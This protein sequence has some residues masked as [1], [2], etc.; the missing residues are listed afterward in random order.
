[1]PATIIDST[2]FGDIFSTAAMRHIWSDENR[3]Q[4]YLDVEAA[5][6][7]VQARLGIIPQA[8]AD[9]IVRNCTIDKID[10]AKL[11]GP[12]RAHRLPG[13]RRRLAADRAVPRPPRRVLPLGRDDAGHH[14]YGHGAA[15]PR[16]ARSRRSGSEGGLGVAR[17]ARA[18]ASRHA[19]DRP[20]QPAAGGAGHVRLQDGRAA[21]R[22]RAPSRAPRPAAPA[23][24]D[25]RV[26]RRGR[27]AGVA[28]DGRARDA[29][30]P[31]EGA[32]PRAAGHRLAHD[33]RLHRR[34]RLL[35]R[36]GRRDARQAV[37]GREADDADRGRRG[38]RAVR[39]R[40]R[41]EQHHAA[42]AQ[43]DLEVLHPRGG[44]GG[45]AARRRADGRDGRRPRA[46]DRPVGDRVDRAAG[47]VLPDLGRAA[48]GAI[49]CRRPRG[50]RGA[51][52]REPRPHERAGRVRGGDDGARAAT[53]DASTRTISCTTSAA[54]RS[55]RIGHCSTCSPRTPR[56]RST[57]TA[58]SSPRC[59]IRR[60]TSG[61]RV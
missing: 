1:M 46:L 60:T 58:R 5:L 38:V 50:R 8:A 10:M 19:D 36:P 25:R 4:K 31:D 39:A 41:V 11:Q 44:R 51:D 12:D 14:R 32:R 59:A 24:A 27:H 52:A 57:S 15:D 26:R 28:R 9:E 35:P 37:D 16:G 53:S 23:R 30:R 48:A 22:D 47:G 43:S 54:K 29:G 7:R 3:T 13:A 40:P 61:C 34:G 42:E 20:Q 33:P 56:S 45:A 21:L 49:G 55:R 2:I 18:Q 17:R 6:A